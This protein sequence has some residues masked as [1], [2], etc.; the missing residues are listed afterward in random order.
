MKNIINFIILIMTITLGCFFPVSHSSAFKNKPVFSNRCNTITVGKSIRFTLHPMKKT[1]HV[2]YSSS[3]KKIASIHKKTGKCIGK[4]PGKVTIYAKVYYKYQNNYKKKFTVKKKLTI[5]KSS[6]LPNASFH[7]AQSINPY[8]YT[9]KL[10]CSRI[11]LKKEVQKSKLTLTKK[12]SSSSLSASFSALSPNGKEITY[13]LS[14]SS[15]KKLCP[16]NGSMNG[17]Y[18]LSS[19]LFRKKLSL[20][21]QERIGNYALS[22]FVLS[23][24][25]APINH[26]YVKCL[27]KD[28]VKTCYTD[29]K[30]FYHL[31]KIKNPSYL[32]VTKTGYLSE[33][34]SLSNT[35][36]YHT[37]C[38]NIFLHSTRK[39]NLSAQFHI[40]EKNGTAIPQAS[41]FVLPSKSENT[42]SKEEILFSGETDSK[43]NILF[44]SD[45]PPTSSSCTKWNIG[46]QEALTY[47][48]DFTPTTTHRKK[49]PSLSLNKTYTLF[50][51]KLPRE[52]TPGYEFRKFIFCP[53]DYLSQQ[54]YFNIILSGHH[55]LPIKNLSIKWDSPSFSL[56]SSLHLSFYQ[57]G[58]T[59]PVLNAKL[60]KEYFS[61]EKNIL[62]FTKDT[63]YTLPDGS[64][65]LKIKLLDKTNK[66]LSVCP[67]T[68]LSI[69][70]GNCSPKELTCLPSSYCR[71]LAYGDF[72]ESDI[73]SSFQ[74]YIL[75]DGQYFYL[76]TFCISYF[77]EIEND[78][79][80][81]SI[82]L[83]DT[84]ADTSYLLLSEKGTIVMKDCVVFRAKKENIFP[85]K[86]SALSSPP[87]AAMFCVSAFESSSTDI[88]EE[89]TFKKISPAIISQFTATKSYIRAASCYPNSII[90]IYK[91]EGTFLSAS[92]STK[93]Y[94]GNNNASNSSVIID[95]YTNGEK[96]VTTQKYY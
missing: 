63:L 15:Q 11:L 50:V 62:S 19:S 12:G 73:T 61:I 39:T 92:L 75:I 68:P 37:R 46:N 2:V 65:Y 5:Q 34:L 87:A 42:F 38:E 21:Y 40:T 24:E 6:L 41:V 20:Y 44:Y 49:I 95:I 94:N 14:Y 53:K 82:L 72:H 25:G 91:K 31:P 88:P 86:A 7:L 59:K 10:K 9:I 52:N 32:T 81:T 71:V 33:T 54:F 36:T 84:E 13:T 16:K 29:N 66:E 45:I 3:N 76:D 90:A 80:T 96:L 89:S 56:C 51:G 1:Y 43:G 78:M 28:S 58:T 55:I 67:M 48:T 27:T 26:A 18:T 22:G 70:N 93:P 47:E 69:S 35:Y 57:K 74:R 64:Y 83:P 60:T 4:K 79:K 17:N 77:S 23:V 85:D 30:G 8:S